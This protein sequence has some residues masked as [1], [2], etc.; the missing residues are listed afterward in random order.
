LTVCK[1][2]N[3]RVILKWEQVGGHNPPKEEEEEEEEEE[4][5]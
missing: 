5:D 4:E 1:V 3:F 2:H